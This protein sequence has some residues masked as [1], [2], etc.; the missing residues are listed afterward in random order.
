MKKYIFSSIIAIALIFISTNLS[1]Q[2]KDFNR[3]SIDVSGGV[4]KVMTTISTGSAFPYF[5]LFRADIGLRYMAN[6]KFGIKLDF[7]MDQFKSTFGTVDHKSQMMRGSLQGVVNVGRICNF[8]DWTK[9][10]SIL[11]HAGPMIGF[12]KDVSATSPISG[13]DRVGGLIVGFSPIFKVGNRLAITTDLSVIGT[14]T[15]QRSFDFQT[16]TKAPG[17][18]GYYGTATVGVTLYLGKKSSHIDWKFNEDEALKKRLEELEAELKSTKGDLD[19]L[20]QD[21]KAVEAKLMDDDNDGV[22][23]YLDIEPNT[24]EGATVNT[25]GQEVK[26]PIVE[27]LMNNDPNLGLFYTVQLGVFSNM[28]TEQYWKGITP[29]YKLK[30][31]DGTTRFYSGIFH[32]VGE[33]KPKLDQ[34]K[35]NGIDDAFITCY[36]RGKRITVAE[37]DLIL[38]TRGESVLRPKP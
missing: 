17:F 12:L 10:I 31:E 24:P 8:E 14:F 28:I 25:K 38:S 20:N 37:A 21:V 2:V 30:I 5:G 26:T 4:N 29:L 6:S 27:D 32:S 15:Q 3:L 36:Y 13:T 7:G 23:N 16:T 19:L 9:S 34:A 35:K 11:G 22:A 1:A 18:D 33:A